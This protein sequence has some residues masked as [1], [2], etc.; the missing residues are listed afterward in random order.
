MTTVDSKGLT[1]Q[2]SAMSPGTDL[3]NSFDRRARSLIAYGLIAGITPLSMRRK[4]QQTFPA[5]ASE[6]HGGVVADTQ[7]AEN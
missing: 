5:I 6:L 2:S 7:E 3:L 1:A 4:S